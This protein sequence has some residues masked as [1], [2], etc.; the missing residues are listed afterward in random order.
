MENYK[1]NPI[2]WIRCREEGTFIELEKAYIP[3]LKGLDGFSHLNVIWWFSGFDDEQSRSLLQCEQPYKGAP[4]RMGIFATRSP[5]RPNPIAL[6][7]SE[8][9]HIDY[10]TGV[11][12]IAFIDADN[13][14]PVLD[15]KPY[16]PSFDRIETP[17][18]PGWCSSWPVSSEASAEFDWESVFLF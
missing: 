7:A 11:I 1:V 4:E 5:L 17:G 10:E 2:G 9:I 8:V 12:Q 14:T 6:T 16:T 13:N 3:A 18:V 15:I